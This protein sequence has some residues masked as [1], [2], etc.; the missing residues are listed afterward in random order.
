MTGAAVPPAMDLVIRVE[1]T[2]T[3]NGLVSIK[4]ISAKPFQHIAKQ[5]EDLKQQDLVLKAPC[6]CNAAVLS[7]L[8]AMGIS[9]P[10]V[11][12]RPRVTLITTGNEVVAPDSVPSALQ[13]RNSNAALLA[14][15]LEKQQIKPDALLHLPDDPAMLEPVFRESLYSD[16]VITCGGVSAGSRLYSRHLGEAGREKDLS[17][18]GHQARKAHLVR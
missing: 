14:A 17:Q 16:I 9:Q 2:E 4:D 11:F 3:A 5:A 12:T 8:A 6:R 18:I 15:L 1:D 10:Q 13:I 7:V